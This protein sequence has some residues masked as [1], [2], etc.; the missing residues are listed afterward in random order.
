[1]FEFKC[2]INCDCSAY[3]VGN[4]SFLS[5]RMIKWSRSNDNGFSNLPIYIFTDSKGQIIRWNCCGNS[6][7]CWNSW[8][9]IHWEFAVTAP[10]SFISKHGL[11]LSR[12]TSIH[13][14]L[15]VAMQWL[16]FSSCNKWSTIQSDKSS[17][18]SY[19]C[20]IREN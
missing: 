19:T 6:C 14:E 7:P 1:M 4:C 3:N 20:I 8:F 9:S 10:Y 13:N 15:K 18:D 17:S 2:S 5:L 11:L 12:K 16:S